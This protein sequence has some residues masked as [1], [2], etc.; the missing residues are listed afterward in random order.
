MQK[1][2][3]IGSFGKGDDIKTGMQFIG[4]SSS[5]GKTSELS[6]HWCGVRA[7]LRTVLKQGG[8]VLL[9]AG[10]VTSIIFVATKHVFCRHKSMFAATKATNNLCRKKNR[11]LSGQAYFVETKE[12]FCPDK[13]FV[14]TNTCLSRQNI[15]RDKNNSGGSSRQ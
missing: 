13:C 6:E 15:C 7:H 12:V 11:C 14:A 9:L 2:T 5:D 10:A 4:N 3:D 1:V 8:T